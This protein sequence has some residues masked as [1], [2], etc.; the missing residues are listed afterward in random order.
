MSRQ[1]CFSQFILI[2]GPSGVASRVSPNWAICGALVAA[3]SY[4]FFE[5]AGVVYYLLAGVTMCNLWVAWRRFK[6]RWP[7]AS[8]RLASSVSHSGLSDDAKR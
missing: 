7:R 4:A 5:L 2:D 6:L 8:M 3:G 1:R